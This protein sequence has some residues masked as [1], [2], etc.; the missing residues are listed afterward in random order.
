MNQHQ[1]SNEVDVPR[2]PI[3]QAAIRCLSVTPL[4]FEEEARRL[5]YGSIWLVLQVILLIGGIYHL[6]Y[7][8]IS[9]GLADLIVALYL[10]VSMILLRRRSD[11]SLIYRSSATMLCLL[12]IYFGWTGSGGDTTRALWVVGYPAF[13]VFIIGSQWALSSCAVLLAAWAVMVFGPADWTPSENY[14]DGF[15]WRFIGAFVAMTVIAIF[16]ERV[17]SMYFDALVFSHTTLQQE[18]TAL[19]KI[20]DQMH[21]LAHRDE[22]TGIANR[23]SILS[24]LDAELEKAGLTQGH[25]AIALLDLDRFKQVND[26][27]GHAAGDLVLREFVSRV[28]TQVRETDGFGRYGGEEFLLIVPEATPEAVMALVE[29]IRETTADSPFVFGDLS[30][31]VT[32]SG[33]IAERA[34]GLD[35]AKQLLARADRAL[36]R[37]KEGGRNKVVSDSR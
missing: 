15:G 33:G 37:A 20:G 25:L 4:T 10:A 29:R 1:A 8:P 35:S 23:R 14:G 7:G 31:A 5:L 3:W 30:V 16:I 17:R 32:V 13:A 9:E 28:E 2:G 26:L 21:T 22:L 12:F 27:H 19:A 11:G 34:L 24:R 6:A 18:K 36:Y